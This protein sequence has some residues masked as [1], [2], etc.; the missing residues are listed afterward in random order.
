MGTSGW[1]R[2]GG[3][4]LVYFRLLIFSNYDIEKISAYE[5][6][7]NPFFETRTPFDVKYYIVA[8]LFIIFDLEVIFLFPWI[9][10]LKFLGFLGYFSVLIFL[11]ILILGFFYEWLKGALDW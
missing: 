2:P 4:S 3:V 9:S 8:L 10:V 6:G 5:C 7:F 1:A 11:V